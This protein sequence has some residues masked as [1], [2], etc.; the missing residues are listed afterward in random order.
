MTKRSGSSKGWR[1]EKDQGSLSQKST[2]HP[3]A[4]SS[5]LPT[6][7]RTKRRSDGINKTGSEAMTPALSQAIR[8]LAR[9]GKLPT[10]L[11]AKELSK[12][13]EQIRERAVFSAR[14]SNAQ[15]LD[16]IRHVATAV[17]RG[18]LTQKQGI[19]TLKSF[20]K[21]EGYTPEPG[22]EGTI[23]DLL[24]PARLK[25]IV[26]TN[27]GMAKGYG[28]HVAA[29]E[30]LASAPW[31]ELY[32][33]E[34]RN[35]PRD[36]ISRWRG[37]GGRLSAGRMIAPVNAPIWSMISGFGLPYPPFDYN[38]GMWT[39]QLSERKV[40]KK[41]PPQTKEAPKFNE[42]LK[43]EAVIR[44]PNLRRQLLKD[45]GPGYKTKRGVLTTTED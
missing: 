28:Q 9:S 21:A 18:E 38:S 6:T 12:I 43:S 32:R 22:E 45:L 37:A 16:E 1:G 29:Q 17:S 15:I 41:A 33:R 2:S 20:V 34:A 25:L 3:T 35:E 11:S 26:K 8:K 31:Q 40:G 14:V 39:R 23:K 19:A 4:P 13:S 44:D 24:S 42:T 7:P 10:T 27:A 36:W 30:N 5:Q